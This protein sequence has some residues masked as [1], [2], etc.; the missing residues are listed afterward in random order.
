MPL[1]LR[2]EGRQE[3][4]HTSSTFENQQDSAYFPTILA[5]G[6]LPIPKANLPHNLAD[7]KVMKMTPNICLLSSC[8]APRGAPDPSD[9][10][11]PT[12]WGPS[13]NHNYALIDQGAALGG[14][15][16]SACTGPGGHLLTGQQGSGGALE[17]ALSYAGAL[18]AA[19]AAEGTPRST[20][21]CTSSV[22][23]KKPTA[24]PSAPKDM[25]GVPG[26]VGT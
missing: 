2:Q 17:P 13:S 10:S 22:V 11:A 4:R 14:A 16:A 24:N 9:F 25:P 1:A 23:K 7:L 19:C 15:A 26:S 3:T 18:P 21:F 12:R 6:S 8:P 5:C 20:L